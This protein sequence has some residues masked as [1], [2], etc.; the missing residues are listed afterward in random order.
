MQE[1]IQG[2]M[3]TQKVDGSWEAL[4]QA[5]GKTS[6]GLTQAEASA[7]MKNQL[8]MTEDGTF[9]EP[10]TSD[11]FT[12]I[13]KEIALYLEGHV[14]DQLAIH[15]GFARLESFESGV[16]FIKLGGGCSGCPSSAITLINGV[17]NELQEKFGEDVIAD[18]APSMG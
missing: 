18:V 7:N 4:H 11:Q 17:K 9:T 10:L 12:G 8:E 2:V 14:S 13:H 15:S 3:F 1:S 5:S 16:A 6:H